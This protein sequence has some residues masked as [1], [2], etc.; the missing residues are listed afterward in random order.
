[1]TDLTDEQ[2][3]I[4]DRQI[5]IWGAGVQR[6]L[7]DAKVLVLGCT[8]LAAEVTKNF[9][10]A[11][12]GSLTLVDDTPVDDVP[13]TFLSMYGSSPGEASTVAALYA[14]GLQEMNPMV[15]VAPHQGKSNVLPDKA[16]L[17][18]FHLLL[19]FGQDCGFLADANDLCRDCQVKFICAVSKGPLVWG[20]A[21]LIKHDCAINIDQHSKGDNRRVSLEYAPMREVVKKSW[22]SMPRLDQRQVHGFLGPWTVVAQF[23]MAEKRMLQADDAAQI[24]QL[25]EGRMAEQQCPSKFWN[26]DMVKQYCS[27]GYE[28][29]PANAVAGGFLANDVVRIVSQVGLPM[30]NVLLYSIIDNVAQVQN[31]TGSPSVNT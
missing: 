24:S 23:E 26:A 10:L 31:L 6:R 4:Y 12:V 5:R 17:T 7:M 14:A 1:M 19:C 29:A 8:P 25:G 18:G 9:I 28:F 15:E 2:A 27:G 22:L 21:D 11:G 3:A 30:Y 20:F 13:M 16:F